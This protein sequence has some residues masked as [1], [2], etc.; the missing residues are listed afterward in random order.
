M[1][2]LVYSA[3]TICDDLHVSAF[4]DSERPV[5]IELAGEGFSFTLDLTSAEAENFATHLRN[6]A[7]AAATTKP[8]E[9]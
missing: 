5:R 4:D 3:D 9:A 7:V 1:I 8:A 2:A 6:A